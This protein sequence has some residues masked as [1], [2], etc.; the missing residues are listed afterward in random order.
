[1]VYRSVIYANIRYYK[2]A[3]LPYYMTVHERVLELGIGDVICCHVI[4]YWPV[5]IWGN[6]IMFKLYVSG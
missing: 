1:M 4:I 6:T 2:R 3:I 5:C